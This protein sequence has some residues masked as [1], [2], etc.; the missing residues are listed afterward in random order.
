M[1]LNVNIHFT[2]HGK[3]FTNAGA[4]SCAEGTE[5]KWIGSKRS[6]GERDRI[7]KKKKLI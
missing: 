6:E 5:D 1:S 7:L 4:M 3:S 2:Y